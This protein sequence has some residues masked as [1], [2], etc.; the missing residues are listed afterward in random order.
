MQAVFN[1]I[2]ALAKVQDGH[3]DFEQNIIN[4]N[5]II[6]KKVEVIA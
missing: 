2:A 4:I 6:I 5:A 1:M 3:V